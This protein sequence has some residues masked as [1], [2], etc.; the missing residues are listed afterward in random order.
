M[1]GTV[2]WFDTTKGY[3]F[4]VGDDGQDYFVHYKQ[5]VEGQNIKEND[6]VTFESADSDRGKQAK[7]VSLSTGSE[8][9]EE[10]SQEEAS[11]EAE[12]QPLEEAEEE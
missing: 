10:T 12:E 11:E 4:I 2:K 5:V 1:E 7:N 3:G 6:K 8:A 9:S